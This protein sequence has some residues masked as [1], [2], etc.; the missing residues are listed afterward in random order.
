MAIQHRRGIYS[1]FDPSRLVPGEWAIVLTNDPNATDGMAAY[2]CFAAGTV[3]R[4][5][6]FEDMVDNIANANSEIVAQ[7]LSEATESVEAAVAALEAVTGTASD[8]EAA[9]VIAENGRVSAE[10]S[11]VSAESSRAAAE[12]SRVTAE[13]ARE[14]VID[15]FEQGVADGDFDGATFT[16]AVS[17]QGVLSWT[18]DKGLVNPASVNVKGDKGDDGVIT[19]LQAGMY[20]LQI[21]S[22]GHLYVSFGADADVP[23]LAIDDDGHLYLTIT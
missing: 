19:T 21:E 7:I 10:S 1:D 15:E 3:K 11:R 12:A 20:A 23:D 22:N 17:Q 4:V 8:G 6:T 18:N 13:A 2:I 9:R 16:P 14:A 5:A